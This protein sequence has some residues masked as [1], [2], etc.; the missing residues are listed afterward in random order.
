MHKK[1]GVWQANGQNSPQMVNVTNEESRHPRVKEQ[2]IRHLS[3]SAFHCYVG[4]HAQ[5]YETLL[6]TY[7][8]DG[9]VLRERA[10]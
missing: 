5:S 3:Q 10:A 9:G 7:Q 4:H 8:G 6:K 1:R 2:V